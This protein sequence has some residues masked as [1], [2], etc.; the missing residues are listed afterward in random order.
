MKLSSLIL[1]T[2]ALVLASHSAVAQVT[3]GIVSIPYG[4]WISSVAQV[5]LSLA[6]A[7]VMWA[8]R[9]VPVQWAATAKAA[10]V[11]QLLLKAIEFG[12]GKVS[13]ASKDQVLKLPVAN[14]VLEKAIEYALKHGPALLK[15]VGIDNVLLREKIIARLDV[16]PDAAMQ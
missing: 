8:L 11:D 13:G 4:E 16:H 1:A 5:V 7:I 10:R 12:I 2:L 3:D 9:A 14:A 15:D 6:T